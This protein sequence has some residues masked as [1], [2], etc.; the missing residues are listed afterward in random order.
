MAELSEIRV[1]NHI[2][3]DFTAFEQAVGPD[4]TGPLLDRRPPML[5]P[6]GARQPHPESIRADAE[7][8][9]G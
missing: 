7:E 5:T 1:V 3:P 2:T 9:R 4:A 6:S 8:D